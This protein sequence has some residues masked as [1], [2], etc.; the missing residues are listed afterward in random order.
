MKKLHIVLKEER[1]NTNLTQ[2]DVANILNITQQA[3]AH[4]E[5]GKRTPSIETLIK[6]ADFYKVSLDYLTGRYN[7]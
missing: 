1:E 3:Y 2:T 6:L 7:N 5:S 4:Y